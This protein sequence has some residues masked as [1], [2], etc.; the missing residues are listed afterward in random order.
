MTH[1]KS[2]VKNLYSKQKQNFCSVFKVSQ[3][4][5]SHGDYICLHMAS[6]QLF[7]LTVGFPVCK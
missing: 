5:L 1:T 3:Q 7:H 6:L 2:Q 4:F